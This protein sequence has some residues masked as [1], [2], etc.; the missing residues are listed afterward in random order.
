MILPKRVLQEI[1]EHAA[2]AYPEE[3]CGALV[4]EGESITQ[5]RRLAN[6]WEG[7]G[8]GDGRARR[9]A[10]EGADFLALE[11]EFAG[12]AEGVLGFYHSHPDHPAEPS[13]FDL[14]R[15]WPFYFYLI[16]PVLKGRPGQA[17][18]WRKSDSG[19]SFEEVRLKIAPEEET[20]RQA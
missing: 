16:V 12:R 1:R 13:A 10:V 5:A 8:K 9:Y 17:R 14:E 18:A 4:G 19:K 2:S 6:A 20:R 7:D 11:R 3:C 15:A